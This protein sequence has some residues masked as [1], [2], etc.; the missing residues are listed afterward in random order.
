MK[1]ICGSY[2]MPKKIRVGTCRYG[3]YFILLKHLTK[4]IV[5]KSEKVLIFRYFYLL[6][7]NYHLG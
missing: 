6:R 3:N 2:F 5:S 4:K 7:A 1:Y